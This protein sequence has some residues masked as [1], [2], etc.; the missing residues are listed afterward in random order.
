MTDTRLGP[1]LFTVARNLHVSYVRSRLLEDSTTAGLTALWPVQ[2]RSAV[3]LRVHGSSRARAPYRA[4]AR[5]S[6]RLLTRSAASR[7][8]RRPRSL[9]CGRCLRHHAGSAE[10]A[11]AS[12]PRAA[13]ASDGRR[14]PCRRTCTWRSHAM[15]DPLLRLL[16]GLPQATPDAARADRIRARCHAALARRPHRAGSWIDADRALGTSRRR[17]RRHLSDRGRAP[18]TDDVRALNFPFAVVSN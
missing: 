1:W 11:P 6:S 8:R 5:R 12:R 16:H 13:D 15:T 9:G 3:S 17:H 18:G 7:G 2:R 14:R 10:A 4:G